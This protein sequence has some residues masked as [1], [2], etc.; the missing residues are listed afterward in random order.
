MFEQVAD[1]LRGSVVQVK[2]GAG[3]GAGVVWTDGGTIVTNAH[4]A[5]ADQV[6]IVRPDGRA[7]PGR[8]DH[9]DR[10]RDVATVRTNGLG[11][12]PAPIGRPASLRA[13]SLVFAIGHPFGISH[14]VT[15]GVLQTIG[16]APEVAGLVPAA[17][18]LRWLQADL[19]LGPGNSGG[20]I[21]DASGRVVGIAAM[22]VGGLALAVPADEVAVR[23]RLG[24]TVRQAPGVA[25]GPPALEIDRVDPGTPAAS[26]GL[27]RGDR[28]MAVAG[29]AVRDPGELVGA[30]ERAG[31]DGWLTV[32]VVRGVRWRR[33]EVPMPRWSG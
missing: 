4:V 10:V 17:R 16:P 20:P 15:G 18:A 26:A 25:G 21:A 24:I 23:P 31:P 29:Q 2:A 9:R 8:V 22:V 27:A 7:V 14:A 11:L 19:A 28:L 5:V 3:G 33:F 30:V 12:E 1:R 6:V 32:D 13:A